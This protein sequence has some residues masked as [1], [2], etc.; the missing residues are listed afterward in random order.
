MRLLGISA[1]PRKA[2]TD[3]VVREALRIAGETAEVESEYFSLRGK[4]INFCI[5]C[6]HCIRKGECVHKDAMLELYPLLIWADAIVIG[7]PVYQGTVSGQAKV[8]MDRC[9]AIVARDIH[10]LRGKVGGAVAVGGDRSGGQEIAIRT[11]IDFYL[12][13]EITPVGGGAFGAN[14]GCVIWSQ[15]KKAEGAAADS[16]GLKSLH[17]MVDRLI[18]VTLE[19]ASKGTNQPR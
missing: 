9:R 12:I 10:A 13:N 4:K 18:W 15:D 7:T 8:M 17:K 3:Y 2:A 6:D 16:E 14:L 5:H 19:N 11:I 1:S